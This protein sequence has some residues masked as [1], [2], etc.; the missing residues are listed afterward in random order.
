MHK[1]NY[2]FRI[3]IM[4]EILEIISCT[5]ILMN[6]IKIYTIYQYKFYS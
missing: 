4:E 5:E 2:L 1:R 3:N 6:D